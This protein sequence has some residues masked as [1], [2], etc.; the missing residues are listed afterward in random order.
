MNFEQFFE[1]QQA[2]LL[3][4][5]WSVTL[6]RE[7]ARDAAQETMA[8]AWERWG[9]LSSGNPAA[10]CRTVALNLC[11]SRWRRLRTEKD[12]MERAGGHDVDF[13][14]AD[15]DLV[16]AL[17]RLPARQREAVVLHHLLDLEVG[18]CASAMGVSESSVKA[19]LQRGRRRLGQLLGEAVV[20]TAAV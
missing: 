2:P 20:V 10:W 11:R 7:A 13:A 4:L 15:L 19:H 14:A 9:E 6:D 18:D 12:W 16:A 17:R 3:R 5:C 1:D 8:R